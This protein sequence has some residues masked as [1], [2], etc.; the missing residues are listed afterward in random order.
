[1]SETISPSLL[2]GGIPELSKRKKENNKTK[3]EKTSALM[4]WG[5]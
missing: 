3:E 1:M 2:L 5:S 4:N